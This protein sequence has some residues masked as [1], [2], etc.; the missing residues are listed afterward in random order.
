MM[1]L[2]YFH[3][4]TNLHPT[5]QADKMQ[6]GSGTQQRPEYILA[7]EWDNLGSLVGEA[8]DVTGNPQALV[9][10]FY[11]MQMAVLYLCTGL[12]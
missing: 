11:N 9:F 1:N 4:S 7:L 12:F 8:Q 3:F 10:L 5:D 2:F 6:R